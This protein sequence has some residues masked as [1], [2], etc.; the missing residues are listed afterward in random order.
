MQQILNFIIKNSTRLLFLLLLVISLTLTIQS[1]SYHRSQ[2]VNSANAVTGSVYEKV[3]EVE[4]YFSLQNQNDKLAKENAYLRKLLFNKKDSVSILP[5]DSIKGYDKLEVINSR[6][7]NN[8]YNKTE[9]YLTISSG[10]TKGIKPDMGVISNEGIVGVIEKTSPNYSTVISVL[11]L[12]SKI[13]AKVKRT[14]HFGSL[15]WK[16]KNA[17][18]A[19]LIEI[20]RLASVKKGDTIVTGGRSTIFPENIPVGII[21]RIYMDTET[22]YYTLDVRLFTDMTNLNH[23]YIIK[24]KDATEINK[25]EAETVKKDE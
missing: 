24:N 2:M 21:D 10:S 13:N 12:K 22:N 6:V 14:N 25:L 17:G 3:N 16:A 1:H 7:I 18:Y 19:Q 5:K 23:V 8:S 20:P 11:N 15:I 4:T 9:N